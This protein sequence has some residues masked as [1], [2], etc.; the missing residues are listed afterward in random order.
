MNKLSIR[1]RCMAI[2]QPLN[3][4]LFTGELDSHIPVEWGLLAKIRRCKLVRV[5]GLDVSVLLVELADAFHFRQALIGLQ[6]AWAGCL[7]LF[8]GRPA[9]YLLIINDVILKSDRGAG[10][11]I[12]S[13]APTE[14][15]FYVSSVLRAWQ[16][17]LG[18]LLDDRVGR[19][20]LVYSF[21]VQ[22]TIVPYS[23]LHNNSVTSD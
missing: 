17:S 7:Y 3:P 10:T 11:L 12:A 13:P 18:S 14:Q 20:V 9:F 6:L 4:L 1:L 2:L 5:G 23:H 8:T 21:E 19:V 16:R 22:E 15:I